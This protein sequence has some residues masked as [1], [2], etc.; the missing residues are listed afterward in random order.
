MPND[1]PESS[2]GSVFFTAI[3]IELG[4]GGFALVLG[5]LMGVDVRQWIPRPELGQWTVI[6]SGILWG[7]LAA[8]PILVFINLIERIDW[9]PLRQLK[10]LEDLEVVAELL[11]LRPVELIAISLAAGVGEELLLRGWLLGW[12]AGP[13]PMSSPV[14]LVVGLVVSSVAFGLMHPITP[15]YVVIATLI[16]FYFGLLAIATGNLLVPIVAHAVYDAAHLLMA[17]R[18][19]RFVH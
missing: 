14:M 15:A 17:Q 11:S 12:I 9:E 16:G 5:W 18:Q 7:T 1:E 2:A 13:D 4:L 10:E 8:L 19:K 6:G 3:T